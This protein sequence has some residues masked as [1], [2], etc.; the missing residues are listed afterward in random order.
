MKN[1]AFGILYLIQALLVYYFEGL[2]ALRPDN[3]FLAMFSLMFGVFGAMGAL[4]QIQN[5]DKAVNA[6]RK[7]FIL[8][9]QPNVIDTL[10]PSQESMKRI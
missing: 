6:A 8:M 5:E 7:M 3:M 9:D 1:F 10:H 2:E 4:G